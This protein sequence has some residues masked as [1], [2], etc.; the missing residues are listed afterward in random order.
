M[1]AK[2]RGLVIHDKKQAQ[3]QARKQGK[4]QRELT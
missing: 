1:P 4:L 3:R 2:E